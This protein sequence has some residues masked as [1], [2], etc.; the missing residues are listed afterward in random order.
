M[1]LYSTNSQ[2]LIRILIFLAFKTVCSS[3]RT[4]FCLILFLIEGFKYQSGSPGDFQQSPPSKGAK[5]GLAT[6]VRHRKIE[7][8]EFSPNQRHYNRQMIKK[9]LK[10][11]QAKIIHLTERTPKLPARITFF[12]DHTLKAPNFCGTYQGTKLKIARQLLNRTLLL[13]AVLYREMY[14]NLLPNIVRAVPEH[15]DLGLLCAYLHLPEKQHEEFFKLWQVVSP[16]RYYG[17]IYYNAPF[18]FPLFNRVTQGTFLRYILSHFDELEPALSP[19]T[20][21]EYIELLDTFMLN[22]TSPLNDQELQVLHLIHENPTATLVQLQELSSLSLGSLSNY[23]NSFREKLLLSRFYR[24]DYPRIRLNHIAVLAYPAP[25][26]RVSRYLEACPYIRK[27]HQFGGA[28]APIL[29]S[30]ILPRLRVR[31]LQEFLQELVGLGHLL[32]YRVYPLSGA[33]NGY[34]LRSYLAHNSAVPVAE[35]FRWVAWIRYLRDVLIREGYGEILTRPYVY[36]YSEPNIEPA[37]L[38]SVDFQLLS[39]MNPESTAEKLAQSL[40]ISIH[41]VRRRQKKLFDQNVIFERPDL[42]M[43]HLGLNET[44]FIILEG[45]EETVR[46]FLAGCREAPMYGGSVFHHPTPGCIVAF[47]LPTGLALKVGRELGRL[48]LE[49][50]EFDA[51]VFYGNGSKDFMVTSVLRRCQF[52]FELDQWTWHREYFPTAFDH[53]DARHREF[54]DSMSHQFSHSKYHRR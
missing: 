12:D 25:G 20:S 44:I 26:S 2:D 8:E 13:D 40:G 35:R 10:T 16:R 38:D 14:G 6:T 31:R 22:Y 32:R 1:E 48:F 43:F 3:F 5:L 47:G 49:Q 18:S 41:M 7:E 53:V 9:R 19:L 50:D 27:I 45:S 34:N 46:N 15:G 11:V 4:L 42:A 52:N 37:N 29:L 21:R 17:D 39:Q 28:G 24:I 51:A 23:L 36:Q 30:Y 54:D 33:F